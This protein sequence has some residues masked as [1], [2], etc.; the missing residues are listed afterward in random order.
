[1]SY[2]YPFPYTKRNILFRLRI[3]EA[4]EM[5]AVDLDSDPPGFDESNRMPRPKDILEIC[6]SL[7]RIDINPDGRDSLGKRA[8]VQTLTAAHASVV[9]FLQE[10]RVQIG[11]QLEVFYTRSAANLEMAETCLTYLL[12]FVEGKVVLSDQNIMD[13][14]FARFSA[15]LWDDFYREV[16]A[17]SRGSK[18]DMTRVDALVMRLFASREVMLPWI[19]LCDPDFDTYRVDFDLP[20]S[21]VQSVMYYAALLGLPGVVSR[22]IKNGHPINEKMDEV[23]G[24]PLVAACVHGRVHVVSILLENGA[25][26]N[27]VGYPALGCPLA[28]AIEQNHTT[29]VKLLLKAKG[30]D[31]NARRFAPIYTGTA[32]SKSDTNEGN[33]KA[34]GT[35]IRVELSVAIGDIGDMATGEDTH[36]DND[37]STSA[38]L[39]SADLPFPIAMTDR[40]AESLI[41]IAAES[42]SLETVNALLEAGANPNIQGGPESTALQVACRCGNAEIVEAL[43]KY[44]ADVTLNGETSGSPLQAACYHPSLR[45]VEVLVGTK[46]DVNYMGDINYLGKKR[47]S[48][49]LLFLR[50]SSFFE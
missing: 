46:V 2:L 15:E 27:L 34:T 20:I 48:C 16:D 41:Y 11:R 44:S 49:N 25:D 28:A 18:I 14:P 35:K 9:D 26:P 22:L 12:N 23:S 29:I 19:Q 5:L 17:S 30:V 45:I 7:V 3:E 6:G 50:Q 31:V 47:P 8:E 42:D 33:N 13:Y 21:Y 4:A 43:L 37:D 10:D 32:R 1:M 40:N 36:H 39:D 24:T 38:T